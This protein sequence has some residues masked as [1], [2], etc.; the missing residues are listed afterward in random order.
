MQN[1]IWLIINLACKY[2]NVIISRNRLWNLLGNSQYL[3]QGN[4]IN[5]DYTLM[6]VKS[7]SYN[8]TKYLR[9]NNLSAYLIAYCGYYGLHY[10]KRD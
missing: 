4:D 5:K 9:Q 1:Y 8:S 10:A 7:K 2:I 3:C 6:V